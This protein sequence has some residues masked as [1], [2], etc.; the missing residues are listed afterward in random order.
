MSYRQIRSF[1]PA[2]MGKR[3][4]YCLMNCRVGFGI[5]R[6]TYSSALADKNAQQKNGTLH[7]I[8]TIPKNCAVPVYCDTAS[9]YEHVV[10][11]NRGTVYS[12]GYIVKGG[13]ASFKCFGW[14]EFCDGQRVVQYIADPA[15]TSS[16][17]PPKG[18]WKFGDTDARIGELARFMRNK[19]PAY[20]SP[21]ALG[22]YYGANLRASI[23]EFQRRTGLVTDG[24]TGP[25]TLAKLNQFGFNH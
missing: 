12:D 21:K 15:P 14:G 16:F 8:S 9:R 10:V 2:R 11:Y 20:T 18:Y 7:S 4:G 3:R 22:N 24:M 25:K 19:F 13:L 5:S 23:I 6:G 1:N 17:L